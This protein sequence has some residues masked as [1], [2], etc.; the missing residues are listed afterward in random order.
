MTRQQQITEYTRVN[1]LFEDRFLKPVQAAIH[2]KVAAV[3]RKLKESGYNSAIS[4]ITTDFANHELASV[5][6]DLYLIVGKK[7]AQMNYSRLLHEQRK[8]KYIDLQ[9]QTKGFGFNA[10]W[11]EFIINYL[12]RFLIEKITFDIATTT[13]DA[14][15]RT[16]SIF[17]ITEGL[18]VDQTISRLEDWPFERYQA[19]RIV[20][21]EVNRA[22]NVGATAQAETSEYQ[23]MKEW[24]ATHDN[25]T[26]GVNPKDHASHI[27]L[28][29]VKINEDDVFI[30]PRNG[31]RLKFPGDPAA[32]AESTINC[33]CQVVY[34]F[35][36]D[37]NGNLIPKR[38]TTTV[39]YP[40]QIRRP[41][42]VT[43]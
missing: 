11:A 36:R 4:F 31:D 21:T 19:A 40:G 2:T 30:D 25:R 22:A 38:K 3:I 35:K 14:L 41:Q 23:Q 6:E 37:I 34:T 43:I 1:R 28:D 12:K 10:R 9:L 13:R 8:R 17:Q 5:V 26:R 42:T 18:S 15:L 33:R 20:R 32:S 27:G 16:M 29:G 24:I 7:H 39:I